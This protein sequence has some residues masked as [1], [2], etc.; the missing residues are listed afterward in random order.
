MKKNFRSVLSFMLALIMI[1]SLP[2]AAFADDVTVVDPP[3]DNGDGTSTVVTTT[4]STSTDADG[5]TTVTVTIEKATDGT[6]ADGT[7]VDRDEMRSDTTI[8][9]EDG[10]VLGE[11]FVEDGKETTTKVVKEDDGS[12]PG[13]PEL[14]V[15]LVPGTTT[16]AAITSS[17]TTGDTPT[18]ENDKNYDYTVTNNTERD[19]TATTS[20]VKVTVNKTDASEMTGLQSELKFDRDS[21]AD[22]KAQQAIRDLYTDNSHFTDPDS[23]TVSG[24]PEG[25]EF[26]YVGYGDYSGHYVSHIRVIYE[27]NEDGSPVVDENGDY[28]IKELQHSNGTTLTKGGKPTTDINGPFDQTTGTRGQQFLLMNEDG[29]A[30]YAYCIDLDT[31]TA[32]GKPWYAMANLEDND[33]YV[34][35]DAEN[36]V[37]SIVSNGY[38]GTS[39]EQN[40][41]GSYNTGSLAKIKDDMKRALKAGQIDAKYEV[42]F[43][44]REKNNGRELK[45]GEYIV[46]GYICWQITETITLTE[47]VIDSMTEGEALD[48]TQSAI[49][50]YANGS[51]AT[52]NGTDKMIVGDL[53]YASSK[54]GD[55][56]NG[57]NDFAGAARTKAFYTYL[58]N[59]ET[60]ESST[61]IIN[62]KNFVND[63]T[64]SIGNKSEGVDVN[65]DNDQNNDVYDTS[66]NF[67]LAF[68]PDPNSDDLLIYLTDGKGNALKDK[69]GNDIVKRLAGTNSEGREA[70]TILP[71]DNGVYTLT[72]LQLSENKDF[73]FDLRLEGTQYL[74]QGVYIYTAQGGIGKSQT[75]V[76]IAKGTSTVDVSLGVTVK[77]DVDENNKV[78]AERVW[79]SEGDPNYVPPTPP[80]PYEPVP[81]MDEG[82]VEEVIEE[83]PVPL[84]K[85]PGTGSLSAVYAIAAAVAGM[86]LAGLAISSKR[87]DEE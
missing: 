40:S 53:Y 74:E 43:V 65:I 51:N 10:F 5:N 44:N 6:L 46:G 29:D 49:W 23:I 27:R 34:T 54:L 83:E 81:L 58:M 12:K 7:V 11:S 62:E 16:D 55:S 28:V 13:Q 76:G 56:R 14:N 19:V 18:G 50:S 17:T 82:E 25:Y 75:M 37:R 41:D 48:A 78:V 63:L 36:H 69:D 59:L 15:E 87:K 70:D 21:S 45:E 68:V 86:G 84:A 2:M 3:V 64:L 42:T 61:T 80:V 31:G 66:I 1:V 57:Q 72:G 38:W 77:F 47:E 35:E 39:N 67:T 9:A 71:D 26:Q 60:E 52:L 20:E 73:T 30:F 32:S 22:Q 8:E 24:A 85:A 79:H 4:T 33:Y